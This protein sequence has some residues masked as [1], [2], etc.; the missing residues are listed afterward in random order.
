MKT[1]KVFL[2]AMIFMFGL[3]VLT[4]F[5]STAGAQMKGM[6]SAQPAPVAIKGFCPVC[7][8]NNMYMEGNDNFV[9]VYKGKTYKFVG[10]D[11]QKMF[12]NDPEKFLKGLEAKYEAL[13][14][15]NEKK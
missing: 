11:Q 3:T 2:A 8:I 9:T 5:V 7:I 14:Q 12:L 4:P 13:S 15:K 1:I 10:F 6:E